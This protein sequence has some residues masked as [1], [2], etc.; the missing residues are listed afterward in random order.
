M[1]TQFAESDNGYWTERID[2]PTLCVFPPNHVAGKK[3]DGVGEIGKG[4]PHLLLG[5]SAGEIV[6][7]DQ[8]FPSLA[9]KTNTIKAMGVRVSARKQLS[10]L[11]DDG[12]Q[13]GHAIQLTRI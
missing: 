9:K 4:E 12:R 3:E 7:Y 10:P 5:P 2:I 13:I 1:S 11:R 8:H 6:D